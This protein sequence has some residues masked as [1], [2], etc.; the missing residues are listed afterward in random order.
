MTQTTTD[1][2]EVKRGFPVQCLHCGDAGGSITM[3]VSDT[4]QFHC[5]ACDTDFTA[6]EVRDIMA[7]WAA[8][9]AW[10]EQAPPLS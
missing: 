6:D 3:D 4:S 2:T 8:L 9:L 10:A 5:H 1:A 7:D